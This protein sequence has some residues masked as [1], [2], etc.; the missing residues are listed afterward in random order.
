VAR[1]SNG[2]VVGVVTDLDDPERL[3]RVKVTYPHLDD[4][5]S[6]WAPLVTLMAG[7]Q[8]GAFFRPEAQDKV[9]LGFEHGDPHRPYVLGGIWDSDTQ[10]PPDDGD[11][12]ANNWRFIVSR[13]GHVL[14]LDDTQGS[15]KIEI[16]DKDGTRKVVIDSS[17]SKIQISCDSGDVEI[18]APSG[19]VSVNATSIELKATSTIDVEATG[20]LTLKGS[21]VSIN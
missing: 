8:R 15:E 20:A 5:E 12:T 7:D 2:I 14:K 11:E 1:G 4:E 18:T 17:G 9:L 6:D 13:S 19:K 3:G 21:T 16:V 10:P